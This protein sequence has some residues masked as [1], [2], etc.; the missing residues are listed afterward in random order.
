MFGRS[1]AG[2]VQFAQRV[3]RRVFVDVAQG[4]IVEDRVDE[5]V[6]VAAEAEAGQ[7]DVNQLAGELADD[8]HAE[9]LAAGDLEDHFDHPLGVADNLA[10]AMVAVFVLA[11]DVRNICVFAFFFGFAHLGNLRDRKD[12]GRK[13]RGKLGLV[14]Q[15]KSVAHGEATLL[16][17]GA[18]QGGR[19]DYVAGDID[20][21]DLGLIGDRIEP[22]GAFALGIGAFL[23]QQAVLID[24]DAQFLQSEVLCVA[25]AAESVEDRIGR[26]DL[27]ALEFDVDL[28]V[29][30]DDRRRVFPG[31]WEVFIHAQFDAVAAHAAGE[32]LPDLTVEQRIHWPRFGMD[33]RGLNA[34][35]VE[36]TGVFRSDDAAADHHHRFGKLLHLEHGGSIENVVLVELNIFGPRRSRA[37]GDENDFSA[38]SFHDAVGTADLY[39]VGI[40]DAGDTGHAGDVMPGGGEVAGG[41][42]LLAA[43]DEVLAVHKALQRDV[44]FELYV[45]AFAELAST[46]AGEEQS[47][48]AQSF[49]C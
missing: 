4:R 13:N 26:Q 5:E 17:A 9:E 34:Q 33:Q 28:A 41:A 15:A 47:R 18:G 39:R 42:F 37:S 45:Q 35:S 27:A 29:F 2:L 48:F 43:L 40:D 8:V 24:R 30:G 10:T 32:F 46:E 22:V 23:H 7:S 44:G 16:H 25:V 49:A 12:A 19:S 1:L 20:A 38:D 31:V 11:D 6:D 3:V 14:V 36:E 21:G